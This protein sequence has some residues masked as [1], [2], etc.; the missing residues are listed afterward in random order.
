[1]SRT[2]SVGACSGA[3]AVSDDG[4][5]HRSWQRSSAR[6]P[7]EEVDGR[8]AR[9][10]C[11]GTT[12]T[13][14]AALVEDADGSGN[15]SPGDRLRTRSTVRN[16]GS[17]AST[18]TALTDTIDDATEVVAGSLRATPIARHDTATTV[19]NVQLDVPAPGV[20]ANDTDPDGT[21]GV[22]AQPSTVASANGGEVTVTRTG[23]PVQPAGGVLGNGHV[24]VH[25]RRR[26]VEHGH[27][28]GDGH[29][30]PGR[31]V[32]RQLGDRSR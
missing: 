1:M 20:L 7:L 23:V 17:D 19:G 27:G 18:N 26:R 2:F 12:A 9:G 5:W 6:P 30:R 3:R 11:D 4:C 21:G 22:T 13:K 28:G 32:H 31:L 10:G 15:V 8:P 16:T 14:T 29:G 24:H 25:G